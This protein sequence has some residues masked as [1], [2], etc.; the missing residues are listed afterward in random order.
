MRRYLKE[1]EERL[2]LSKVFKEP[3]TVRILCIVP[4]VIDRI[5]SLPEQEGA[6]L[7]GAWL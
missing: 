7:L 6:A 2:P 3:E 1:L 4:R 5:G